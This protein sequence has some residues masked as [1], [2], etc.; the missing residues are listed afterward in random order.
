MVV[1]FQMAL[2]VA[3]IE[4]RVSPRPLERDL[5]A[6]VV[7]TAKFDRQLVEAPIQFSSSTK[8]AGSLM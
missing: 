2:D 3:V 5:E 6:L 1:L 7:T 4:A 8:D